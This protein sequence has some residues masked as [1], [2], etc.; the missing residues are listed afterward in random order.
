MTNENQIFLGN[1]YYLLYINCVLRLCF[2]LTRK[3]EY[4]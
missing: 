4:A 3:N 2:H 1:V